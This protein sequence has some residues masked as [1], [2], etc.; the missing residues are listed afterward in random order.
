MPDARVQAAIDHWGPRFI[1]AGVDANDFARTTARVETWEE[2]LGAWCETADEHVA[3]ARDAEAAGRAVTAGEAWLRAAV[4]FHFAKFVWVLDEARAARRRRPGGRRAARGAPPARPRGRAR[5]GPARRRDGRGKPAAA[6]W[7]RAAAAGRPDRRARLHQGGVLPAREPVP[8]ARDGD[9]VA[10]RARARGRAG[11]ELPLRHD[12]EAGVTRDPRRRCDGFDRIGALGVSLGGYYAPRA[13]AF[14]PRIRAVAGISG[15]FD[16][17]A[18]WDHLPPLTR[19]TFVRKSHAADDEDG[20]RRAA[21]SNL[22]GVVEQL[23]QP[24]LFVTGKLDRLIPWEETKRAADAA[25]QRRVRPVRGRQPRVRERAV[26]GAAAGGRLAAGAARLRVA[27]IGA[28]MWAPRL[29]AAARARRP[30][31]RRGD[32]GRRRRAH[33]HA[34]PR[35]RRERDRVRRRRAARV[36][37]EA[38]RRHRRGGRADPRRLRR[39]RRGADGRPCV[40]AARRR[41]AREGAGRRARDRR[42]RRGVLLAARQAAADRLARAAR[43]QPRRAADAARHPPRRHARVPGSARSCG[44]P[45]ASRTCTPTP[46]STTSAWPRSSSRRARWAC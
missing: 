5:R 25:P 1:Q 20:R 27:L 16:F 36:R 26:Q 46:R 22:D 24:A 6:A 40:P 14:E 32:R 34:Q 8:R 38:D 2:W 45:A 4:C 13:A 41:A 10:G 30:R 33:R 15:P 44:R 31:A 37:R 19:E 17:G 42:A 35:P 9:A 39:G 7:G 11:Y 29:A 12:F 21:R 43:A 3:L 18:I 28:G 23:D